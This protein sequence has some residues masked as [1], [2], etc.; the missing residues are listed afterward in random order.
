[1]GTWLADTGEIIDYHHE[2]NINS[3]DIRCRSGDSTLTGIPE[4]AHP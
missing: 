2:G 3:I 1:M 4:V